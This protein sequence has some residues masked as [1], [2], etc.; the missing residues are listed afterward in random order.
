MTTEI[1]NHSFTS[2]ERNEREGKCI[3]RKVIYPKASTNI[4]DTDYMN[5]F[6]FSIFDYKNIYYFFD[7]LSAVHS[8]V[9]GA[10]RFGVEC[11]FE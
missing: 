2:R 6:Q 11:P 5:N 3:C 10:A 4:I 1:Q 9:D 7:G 8:A